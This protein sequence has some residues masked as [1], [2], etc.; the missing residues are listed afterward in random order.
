M[1]ARLFAALLSGHG[2]SFSQALRNAPIASDLIIERGVQR[3]LNI[4]LHVTSPGYDLAASQFRAGLNL[5][6][7]VTPVPLDQFE[8]CPMTANNALDGLVLALLPHARAS[9]QKH[10]RPQSSR[11][12]GQA[13]IQF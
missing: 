6:D 12:C 10:L 1:A 7:F 4:F 5:I 9:R 8:R 2:L 11:D 13:L 3:P